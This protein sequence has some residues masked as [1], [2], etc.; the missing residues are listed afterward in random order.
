MQILKQQSFEA[1]LLNEAINSC[2]EMPN[3]QVEW[4]FNGEQQIIKSRKDF[5]KLL[6]TVCD[7]VY[8]E[9]PI[10]RN[11]LFNKQKISS[12]ISLARVNL[13]DAMIEHWQ[14]EDFGFSP[15]QYPPERTIY[16][17]LFKSSGIHR[18]NEDG[19][20]I[21][22]EPITPNLQSLWTVCSDFLA[23]CTEKAFKLSDLVKTLKMR[24]Y[25]LK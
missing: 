19:L 24:P 22:G 18:Q 23:K 20:W 6:S 16:N 7:V 4:F 8:N 1:Q 11:E 12:A 25:K 9:T 14:E 21:L 2:V 10:I 3:G 15:T 17:T 5:N 13:L